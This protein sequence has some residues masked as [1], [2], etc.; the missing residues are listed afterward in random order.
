MQL[1]QLNLNL[2]LS[3]DALLRE[4]SVTR[5]AKK[6][7]ISQPA[8]SQN[9]ATLREL[10][11]DKLL[12]RIGNK[13]A[14]TPRAESIGPGLER[15]LEELLHVLS[16]GSSIDPLSMS[17]TLRV[18]TGDHISA[19]LGPALLERVM[20]LAP[21]TTLRLE[22]LD[23][24]TIGAALG[25]GSVDVAIGPTGLNAGNL[26]SRPAFADRFACLVRQD[27][28]ALNAN[29]ISLSRYLSLPHLLISP[30]GRGQSVVDM[31]LASLGKV[32]KVAAHVASFLAA[33]ILIAKTD[34]ILTA[35][36]ANLV[37]MRDLPVRLVAAPLKLPR[38]EVSIY[39]D[40]RRS[41]DPVVEFVRD[42]V[43]GA[44]KQRTR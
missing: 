35:P 5:A 8:M 39:W 3:L 1:N 7:G 41:R 22:S 26:E 24:R 32:R 36:R 27:H 37:I 40:K 18:A 29:R 23:V 31:A 12:V 14:S 33:P 21:K 10:L 6:V 19:L 15:C 2:L 44:I 11:G 43:L 34:L 17:T 4:K 16:F 38:L 28:A 42:L 20:M 30:T 9:L 13:M 25:S